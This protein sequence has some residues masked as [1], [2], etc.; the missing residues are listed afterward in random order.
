MG[1]IKAYDELLQNQKFL[2]DAR[3]GGTDHADFAELIRLGKVF[4]PY[5]VGDKLVFGPSRFLGYEKNSVRKHLTRQNRDGRKTNKAIDK[6]LRDHFGFSIKHGEDDAVEDL[7]IQFCSDLGVNAARKDRKY[8]I[9][10]GVTIW[11]DKHLHSDLEE[12]DNYPLPPDL[13]ETT[14]E[15]IVLARVGQGHFRREVIRKYGKCLI[16]GLDVPPLL[17]AS[18]I[19]PWKFCRENP[20]EC[21]DPENALLLSPTWDKLF[22]LGYISFSADGE[23]LFHKKLSKTVQRAMGIKASNVQLTSGQ[24]RYLKYHRQLY[25]FQS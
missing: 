4:L 3:A 2:N 1:L 11:L 25:G 7:F 14:R 8:W 6:V 15:A 23:M 9:T 24:K 13:P 18:H 21:L 5:L 16:T 20:E 10:P 22:D 12:P 17:I 19:K